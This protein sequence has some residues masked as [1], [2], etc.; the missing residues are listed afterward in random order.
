MN[1]VVFPG[2]GT[3][4]RG[5]GK[6]LYDNF[7]QAKK[8]FSDI[9][10]ILGMEISRICF[11]GK[12][13]ELIDVYN[14]QLAILATSLAAYEVFKEKQINIDFFSGLSLGEYTCLYPAG[15]LSFE[16]LVRL[17]KKR[18]EATQEAARLNPSSMLAVIGSEKNYLQKLAAKDSFYI[19]NINS[20]KQIVVSLKKED[21]ERV[22]SA[23]E[24]SGAKVV[25]LKIAVGFHSPFMEPAKKLLGEYVKNI[26]FK[27]AK[28]PVV[29]NLTAKAHA[30]K[31]QIKNNLIEQLTSSALWQDCVKFMIEEGVD[32]FF[33]IG[34][35]RV[36]RGL[37]KKINPEVKVVNIEKKEDLNGVSI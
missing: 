11:S 30:D 33:E 23:L 20:P 2:H 7:P 27:Q 16:D 17:V 26:E 3:Q 35:S 6:D 36:L 32:V 8:V 12:R 31:D 19:A 24:N 34:P 37:I 10:K 1:A 18:S 21:K 29:S 15:V 9:D 4:Y 14:Q 22:K 5:M 25:E 28:I 13:E